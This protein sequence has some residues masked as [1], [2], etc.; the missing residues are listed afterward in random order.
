MLLEGPIQRL[1]S[2]SIR[3]PS[4]LTSSVRLKKS[5]M[6]EI[7]TGIKAASLLMRLQNKQ[8][9]FDLQ[10]K[11]L[12]SLF[13]FLIDLKKQ[14]L[15][16]YFSRIEGLSLKRDIQRE[17]R[18]LGELWLRLKKFHLVKFKELE[19][20]LQSLDRLRE[21]LGYRQTLDRGYTVIR[22]GDSIITN[23]TKALRLTDLDIEFRDGKLS[24][25]K[26]EV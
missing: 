8:S 9:K 14:N 23:K 19:L 4:S 21:T 10:A 5:K 17:H 7:S 12:T 18:N 16:S 1:D 24:V 13:S 25:T 26:V 6:Y 11:Q 22:S 2:M 15:N 3:L 20:K